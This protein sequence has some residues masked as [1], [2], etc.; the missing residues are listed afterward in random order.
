MIICSKFYSIGGSDWDKSPLFK[1]GFLTKLTKIHLKK[2]G[3][4]ILNQFY[5]R[6]HKFG[7]VKDNVWFLLNFHQNQ[8]TF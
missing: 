3:G 4:L 7:L 6:L 1:R 8:M 5:F 2:I